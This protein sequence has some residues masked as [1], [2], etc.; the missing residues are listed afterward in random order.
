MKKM[1][2]TSVLLLVLSSPSV[3]AQKAVTP[4]D[5]E[6]SQSITIR[7]KG[8]DKEKTTIVIDG[9]KIT[10]NGKP[11]EDYKGNIQIT[12]NDGDFDFMATPPLPPSNL[13]MPHGGAKMFSENFNRLHND[14]FLG[15]L[16]ANNKDGAMIGSVTKNSPAEKAG[17]QKGDVITKLGTSVIANADDLAE[18]VGKY[19]PDDKVTITYKRDNKQSTVMVTLDKNKQPSFAW[20][21]ADNMMMAPYMKNFSFGLNDRPHLGLRIQDIEN[22]SGVK[23][24][25]VQDEDSPAGKAGMKEDDVITQING[26]NVQT[27]N[28]AKEEL[29]NLK[30]GDDITI[31]YQRNSQTKTATIHI[32]KPLQ[33]SDL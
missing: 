24:L 17:L 15:V 3:F 33:T 2:A 16:S 14:A 12:G 7:K 9:D 8:D 5:K 27:V 23:V 21:G 11:V 10:V 13:I 1:F 19:K 6:K 30:P 26:K 28:D 22:G 18:A 32:P 31:S 4:S 25:N 29:A 20:S